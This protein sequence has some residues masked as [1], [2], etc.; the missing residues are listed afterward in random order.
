MRYALTRKP[1]LTL[2]TGPVEAYPEVLQALGRT[3]AYDLDP[4]FLAFYEAVA[5]K[6]R[7]A[8]GT[9]GVPVIL[10]GEAV[11]AL[12][13]AAASLITAEDV[14]LNLVSGVYGKGFGHW[15]RRY[16]RELVEIEV[17]FD[18]AI[19][20]QAVAAMLEGRPEIAVVSV[21]HHETPSGTLN[22]VDEIGAVCARHGALLIVD[23]VSSWGGMQAS[24]DACHAA[25]YVTGPGKCLGCPPGLSLVAVSEAGW[26]RMAANPGAPRGSAL[27]LLDWRD[28]W[29]ADRPFPFTPSVA[30]INGLDRALDLY[31][32]EGPEAVWERHALTAAACRA[33]VQGL[34]LELWPVREAIASPTTTTVKLPAG[35]DG[36]VL[37]A[38]A[39]ERYGVTFA[40][41]RGEV[42]NRLIRIGH[43]GSSAQPILAV[44]AVAALGGAL[45]SMGIR[46]DI[47]NGAA[48]AMAV[49][50]GAY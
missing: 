43:M 40:A 14:V 16:C 1:V 9:A 4:A 10:Q 41:G 38:T 3:V 28:A 42:L 8:M 13:A 33:G 30:E 50:D 35:I 11:L 31:L 19:D 32:E 46:V 21:V 37:L 15:A 6:V 47:G 45:R 2:T 24:P 29:R 5:R 7:R 34:G 23:A 49:I 17:P 12:E 36:D 26:A 39:R 20:P 25:V 22:P 44:A 48:A 27:S 18:D